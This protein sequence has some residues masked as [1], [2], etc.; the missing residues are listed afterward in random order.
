M[1]QRRRLRK[2]F[3]L[4]LILPGQVK[5]RRNS[6]NSGSWWE[7]SYTPYAN[8]RFFIPSRAAVPWKDPQGNQLQ[9]LFFIR[10]AKGCEKATR[11]TQPGKGN[12]ATPLL[13]GPRWNK[14]R[15]FL[16]SGLF[17]IQLLQAHIQKQELLD[18]TMD[19]TETK[20]SNKYFLC[21]W[22]SQGRLRGKETHR[23]PGVDGSCLMHLM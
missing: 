17:K 22:Y 16:T 7:L 23:I 2:I 6:Q 12:S 3:P 8:L 11:F 15:K 18:R 9:G 20:A 5:R 10:C 13:A 4:Y 14:Q 1:Q 19:A 21:S